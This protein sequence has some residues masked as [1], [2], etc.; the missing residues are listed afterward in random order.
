M[1]LLMCQFPR[2][3]A[4]FQSRRHEFERLDFQEI[5]QNEIVVM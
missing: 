4:A 1:R 5:K 2:L 3:Q